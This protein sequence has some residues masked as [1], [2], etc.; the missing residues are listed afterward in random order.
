MRPRKISLAPSLTHEYVCKRQNKFDINFIVLSNEIKCCK[1][2]NCKS[3]P[4]NSRNL[5]SVKIIQGI[6]EQGLKMDPSEIPK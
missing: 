1:A 3:C 4:Q 2:E 5:A 6:I